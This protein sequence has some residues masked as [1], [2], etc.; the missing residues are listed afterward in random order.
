M[1]DFTRWIERTAAIRGGGGA[2][3]ETCARTYSPRVL[4]RTGEEDGAA[5]LLIFSPLLLPSLT[6]RRLLASLSSRRVSRCGDGAAGVRRPLESGVEEGGGDHYVH[7]NSLRPRASTWRAR[8]RP[9]ALLD[10]C[11][12][13]A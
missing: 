11:T 5:Q 8:N 3:K 9:P 2:G 4:A 13:H 1:E 12:R 7:T 10:S 6:A